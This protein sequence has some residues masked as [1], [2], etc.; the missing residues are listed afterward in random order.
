VVKKQYLKSTGR[1]FTKH[2][3]RLLSVTAIFIVSVGL[4]TGLGN[5]NRNVRGYLTDVYNTANVHDLEVIGLKEQGTEAKERLESGGFEIDKVEEYVYLPDF[6]IDD[7]YARRYNFVDFDNLSIDK[8]TL[9]EG[10]FPKN[11][12]EIVMHQPTEE[13]N[14]KYKVGDTVNMEFGQYTFPLKIVGSVKNPTQ[15]ARTKEPSSIL[16]D[17]HDKSSYKYLGEL[18]YLRNDDPYVSYIPARRL[19]LTM[20]QEAR[21]L[22][23]NF[24][25]S[26]KTKVK[27]MKEIVFGALGHGPTTHL[28]DSKDQILSLEECFC[29]TTV[30][31]YGQKVGVISLIFI[32]FFALITILVTYSTMSRLLDEEHGSMAVL[33]TLGYSNF[34]IA[35]RYI[36]F[37]LVAGIIGSA[38][39]LAPAY[40]VNKMI[41]DGFK[42]QF[43]L[44]YIKIPIIS[45]EFFICAG[46]VLLGSLIFI[47]ITCLKRASKKPV[48]L[49]LPKAPKV[50]KT[51]LLERIKPIWSRLSFKYKSTCRNI[52]LFKA[53]FWM[54]LLSIIAS[55]VLIFASFSLLDN[56]FKIEMPGIETLRVI[57][58]VLLL[59]SGL[60]CLIVVYNIT[61]I[62]VSERTR[63]IATLMV[64]GYRRKEVTGY[65]YRE[66]Y[67][68][69]IMGA[70]LG[71]PAGVGF[72]V[73]VFKY[74]EFGEL[75]NVN[76]WTYIVTPIITFIFAF[77]ATKFLN[78][79]IVNTNMN[80]SLKV[81]E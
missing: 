32:T 37:T 26:Y 61:N 68:M 70:L 4:M 62:N 67:I 72:V 69:S 54:T 77:L 14:T 44:S 17:E 3:I 23:N 58:G 6:D 47:A 38:V 21:N 24:S 19:T 9:V 64:L 29:F 81:L 28:I 60:L 31:A 73:F 71:L 63:E 20:K 12:Y 7:N 56:S 45:L 25:D 18:F 48:E 15:F 2:I 34:A 74:M 59:F 51:I 78:R 11:D 75:G 41:I 16:K 22:F 55:T 49:L 66:I 40:L 65:I 53:R 57:S 8:L 5:V 33:K 46:S 39:A 79:K 1:L 76:W 30:A 35:L 10:S 13:I 50:G 52:F 43:A 42:M 36:L 27:E 80:D